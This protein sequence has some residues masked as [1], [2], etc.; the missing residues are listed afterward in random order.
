MND[1]KLLL[2]WVL[3]D[4]AGVIYG[5]SCEYVLSL[6]PISHITP[7]PKAPLEI[8]GIIDFRGHMIKLVNLQKILNV[9]SLEEKVK[10][11]YE[12]MDARKQD[13]INWLETLKNCVETNTEFTLTTDPHKCAFGKWYDSYNSDNSNIMFLS[14]FSKFDKPHKAIH[15]IGEKAEELIESNK[16][17]EALALI[18]LT[19][20]NELKQ[21][22]NL[23]DEIKNAYKESNREIVIVIGNGKNTISI[24]VDNI[25]A[26]EYL[27]ETDEKLV[28]ESMTTTKYLSGLAKRKDNSLVILLNDD[29]LLATASS[30]T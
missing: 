29:Y 30:R 28:K 7:L 22:I 21:M 4:I 20:D 26:V 14:A 6:P 9:L 13:H 23:F 19:K 5:I 24:A 15:Q 3:L 18:N 1:T 10:S 8:R 12:L 2:P 17:S 25:L 11:F 27:T 16:Y